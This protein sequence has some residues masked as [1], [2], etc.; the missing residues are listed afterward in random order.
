MRAIATSIAILACLSAFAERMPLERYQSLIDRQ[1]FGQPPPGFDPAKPASAVTKSDQRG[2][3]SREQEVLKSSIHFSAI[4]VTPDGATAVGFTD[5]SDPKAP[6]H[7]YLKV[8]ETR[9]GW[10]VVEADPV[11]ATMKIEKDDIEVSLELGA[12]SGNGGGSTARAGAQGGAGVAPGFGGA[13]RPGLFGRGP[14]MRGQQ[15]GGSAAG[16]AE[17]PMFGS[18]RERRA[19]REQERAAEAAKEKAQ[20]EAE[21]EEQRKELQLLKDELKAQREAA[22]QREAQREAAEREREER[23]AARRQQRQAEAAGDPQTE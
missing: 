21:R 3:L 18:L 19:A 12:N 13:R 17:R 4:N 6:V 14:M 8:G 16:G 10:K 1:M 11:K 9:N 2:E 20:R 23:E 5:N 22:A 7:Y 15:Q